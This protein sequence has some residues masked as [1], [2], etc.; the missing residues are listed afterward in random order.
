MDRGRGGGLFGSEIYSGVFVDVSG[1]ET[2]GCLERVESPNSNSELGAEFGIT[3][4]HVGRHNSAAVPS[5]TFSCCVSVLKFQPAV[6]DVD[7]ATAAR[8]TP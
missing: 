7:Q 8:W 2:S 5:G 6:Q 1:G 3:T 4:L